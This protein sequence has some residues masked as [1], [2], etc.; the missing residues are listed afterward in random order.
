VIIDNIENKDYYLSVSDNIGKAL[1]YISENKLEEFEVGRYEIDSDN[2]FILIQ[3][4]TTK[5]EVECKWEAHKKY[6]DIQYIIEGSE[7]IGWKPIKNLKVKQAYLN[8]KDVE[9]YNEVNKWVKLDMNT[10]DFAVFFPEDGHKPGCVN[11]I[12][13]KLK[14]AVVKI[15]L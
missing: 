10:G 4:Y 6:I 2:V 9:I 14:K 1:K 5:P 3:A 13:M 7:C 12:P 15:K 11:D 8:E